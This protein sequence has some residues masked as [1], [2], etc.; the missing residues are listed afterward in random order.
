MKG[1]EYMNKFKDITGQKFGKLTALYR[2]NNH[3]K[4]K[5]YGSYWL[6]V[7]ECG[8]LTEVYLGS[9]TRGNSTSCGCSIKK[10]GK[11]NNP[12]YRNWLGMKTR[13]CNK[14]DEHYEDYGERGIK[15]CN[16]WLHDFQA[17]YDWSMS[18]GYKEGLT[19][20]R[21]DVNGD[22]EPN[23]CRWASRKTQARNRRSNRT[24]TINGET[25]CLSEWCEILNLNY[26]TVLT[27][28]NKLKWSISKALEVK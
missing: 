27:R 15:V 4:C 14:T 24:F 23:N 16:E 26:N 2:L 20:D 25:R 21:I 8:N 17:F 10:H 1:G 18:N 28:I 9:L 5:Y 19:I 11:S 7:C 12:L 22:Y 3:K 13:C 6:C